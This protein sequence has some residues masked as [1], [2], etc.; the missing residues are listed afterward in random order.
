MRT[1]VLDVKFKGHK[2][3][4]YSHVYVD[5]GVYDD[6]QDQ[7]DPDGN[8]VSPPQTSYSDDTRFYRVH[9]TS[10]TDPERLVEYQEGT[11]DP[12]YAV[13]IEWNVAHNDL[14][15]LKEGVTVLRKIDK[16]MSRVNKVA[17]YTNS[18]GNFVLRLGKAMGIKQAY[19]DRGFA[20]NYVDLEGAARL[21]DNKVSEWRQ[22][23]VQKTACAG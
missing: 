6:D 5:V 10:Q 16:Y 14:E 19:I 3:D 18:F 8:Q 20:N 15:S 9:L 7:T 1:P 4:R 17:G 13:Y 2:L 21:I 22:A 12:F 11:L 23:A